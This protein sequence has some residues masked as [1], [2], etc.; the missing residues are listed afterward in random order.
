MTSRTAAAIAIIL[1]LAAA[2]AP[3]VSATPAAYAPAPRQPAAGVYS[4][5]D[6][7][8]TPLPKQAPASFY[9]RADKELIPISDGGANV[10]ATAPQ[11][12]ARVHTPTSGSD[13]GDVGIGGALALFII[14]VMGAAAVSQHRKRRTTVGQGRTATLPI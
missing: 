8:V 7:A 6:K 3:A 13:W 10:P 4:R 14:G 9:S 12:M 1:S 11:T 5:P 2:S